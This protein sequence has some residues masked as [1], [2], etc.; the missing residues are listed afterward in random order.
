M[1]QQSVLDTRA[2]IIGAVALAFLA[3][4]RWRIFLIAWILYSLHFATNVVREHYPAFSI[5]EHATF[6]VDEY[7][8]FHPDIFVHRDGHSVIGNQVLVSVLAAVPLFL[9]DPILDSLENYSK[10]RIAERGV[11]D[12]EYRISKRNSVNFFRLVKTRGLDLRFGA[13]TFVTTAFFM[14]P[15]TAWFLSYFY[16]VLRD[17]G[18]DL[19]SATSLTFVFGFGSALFYRATVLGHNM[20][21]MFFMF[22]AFMLLWPRPVSLRRRLW[23][24][25]FAGLTLATDYIGVILLPLLYFYLFI[26]RLSSASWRVSFRESLAMVAGSLPPIAFLL[27]S[28]WAMYGNPFWPG[29]HWMPNQNV[30]VSQGARGFTL[31][32]PDLFWKSLV[33]PAYGLFTWSPILLLALVPIWRHASGALVLPKLERRFLWI[34]SL[35]CLLF[36]SANQ[37]SRLQFNSGFRYLLPLVPLMMLAVADHWVRFSRRTQL[38]IAAIAIL[39]G[40]V[41]AVF[42]ESIGRSWQM[43]LAEGPQLPW[44]RVLTLTSNP[45]SR[46]LGT[47]WLPTVLLAATAVVCVGIWRYG[48]RLET[49]HAAQ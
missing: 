17:R 2:V 27:F 20:F 4:R 47:W 3:S 49:R 29:Q 37:Y 21:V 32:A 7:Q 34:T 31:P 15:L 22:I 40:W 46:W 6:R 19:A 28:Q 8:G 42:R 10:A 36:A 35:V 5:A 12:A 39:H 9:F 23:A 48:A 30:Y 14:A 13:A 33:D 24:G 16:Q 41:I 38:T 25:F 44:Y 11:T 43:F 26:P 18:V 45:D 1:A